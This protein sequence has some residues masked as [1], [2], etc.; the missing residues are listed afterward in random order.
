MIVQCSSGHLNKDLISCARHKA[1]DE[2][3]NFRQTALWENEYVVKQRKIHV[4]FIVSLPKT[5]GGSKFIAFQG[6]K[7]LCIHLDDL[8][9]PEDSQ[10]GFISAVKTPLSQLVYPG[11]GPIAIHTRLRFCIQGALAQIPEDQDHASNRKLNLL[12]TLLELIPEN[13]NADPG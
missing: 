12:Q 13:G 2:L 8:R 5:P 11:C 3:Q 7:W 9:S 4:I 1:L 10:L 6:G